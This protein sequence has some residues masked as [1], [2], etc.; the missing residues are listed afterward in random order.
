MAYTSLKSAPKAFDQHKRLILIQWQ[1]NADGSFRRVA[2]SGQQAGEG[3][4]IAMTRLRRVEGSQPGTLIATASR[5]AETT[6][7]VRVITWFIA[8][9]G[10]V[11]RCRGCHACGQQR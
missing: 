1:V 6:A 5:S 3:S 9:A 8:D 7:R 10:G 4:D 2:D 11:R